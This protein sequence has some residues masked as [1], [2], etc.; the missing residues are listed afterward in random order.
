MPE[1]G[2]VLEG[3]E[4][5]LE[6]TETLPVKVCHVA[7]VEA[8]ALPEESCIHQSQEAQESSKYENATR[9]RGSDATKD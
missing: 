2:A 6:L 8:T 1:I 4:R 9:T 5:P 7:S 3:H